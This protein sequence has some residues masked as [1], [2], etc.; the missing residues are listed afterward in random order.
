VEVKSCRRER[1][2]KQEGFTKLKILP[3]PPLKTLKTCCFKENCHFLP[4]RKW[5]EVEKVQVYFK[6]SSEK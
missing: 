5:Q 3:P 4:T 1:V 2:K 6:T